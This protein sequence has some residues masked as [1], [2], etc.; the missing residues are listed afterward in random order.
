MSDRV[1]IEKPARK[2]IQKQPPA[3]QKRILTALYKL[4]DEGDI[5]PMRG[6]ANQ[7]RVRIGT[8]RAVYNLDKDVLTVTVIKVD[9]RGDV[10]KGI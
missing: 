5:F 1:Y 10:Y 6:K 8:Y 7:Y 3:Q 4:P 2:F 9:N